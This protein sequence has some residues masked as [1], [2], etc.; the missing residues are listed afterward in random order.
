ML[1]PYARYPSLLGRP[2]CGLLPCASLHPL[3]GLPRE[4]RRIQ[5]ARRD[6]RQKHA[7]EEARAEL[8]TKYFSAM[9]QA[10]NARLPVGSQRSNS[11]SGCLTTNSGK[12]LRPASW[13][14]CAPAATAG[15]WPLAA[16]TALYGGVSDGPGSRPQQVCPLALLPTPSS[17]ASCSPGRTGDNL[18][19]IPDV[20]GG[21][22]TVVQGV[23]TVGKSKQMCNPPCQ[24]A[25]LK[26]SAAL[27]LCPLAPSFTPP[28]SGAPSG[29][30]TVPTGL[31]KLSPPMPPSC[32]DPSLLP[33]LVKPWTSTATASG[34]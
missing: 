34:R 18:Q 13:E 4:A 21:T 16:S 5:E 22:A 23:L 10:K 1:S 8:R 33:T 9:Q 12:G 14:T 32:Q 30:P 19:P 28:S 25:K 20:P 7:M 27:C 26:T 17:L 6:A 29:S 11:D 24:P 15:G 3:Y 2:C 31:W